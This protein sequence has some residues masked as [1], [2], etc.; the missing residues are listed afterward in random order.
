VQ[1]VKP[2]SSPVEEGFVSEF[3]EEARRL[4]STYLTTM[5]ESVEVATGHTLA[6]TT[7]AE[8]GTDVASTLLSLNEHGSSGE[9]GLIA[10]STHGRGGLERWVMGS[11]TE[12]LL[13]T[14]KLPMLIVRPPKKA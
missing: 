10:I 3:N 6:L 13:N 5:A 14:T 11:V 2:V 8:T 7:S 12:R 9:Y 1:V 4:A